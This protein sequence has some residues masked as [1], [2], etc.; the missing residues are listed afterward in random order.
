MGQ[1]PHSRGGEVSTKA[2][3]TP[4]WSCHASQGYKRSLF[5]VFGLRPITGQVMSCCRAIGSLWL[6]W[7]A[8]VESS[9]FELHLFV[10]LVGLSE[11]GEHGGEEVE[12]PG[13][14]E[15]I[16]FGIS[17]KAICKWLKHGNCS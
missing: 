11:G 7:S 3:D 5:K 15:G 8:K 1:G 9:T 14:E 13:R 2:Q 17:L 12:G 10:L 4:K 6:Y 16:N